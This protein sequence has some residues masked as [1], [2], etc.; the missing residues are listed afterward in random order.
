MTANGLV[1]DYHGCH[2]GVVQNP[3]CGDHGY[4]T[5]IVPVSNSTENAE[6]LLEERPVSPYGEND[7]KVLYM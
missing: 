3:P 1:T 4:A 5:P 7:V 2:E 6:Q